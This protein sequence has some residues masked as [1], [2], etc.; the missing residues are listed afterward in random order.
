MQLDLLS[1]SDGVR[2]IDARMTHDLLL[3]VHY[4]RRLPSI[5]YAFG[6]FR[7]GNLVG[8]VTYGRPPAA[9]Q[10]SGVCGPEFAPLVYELNRLCLRDNRRN[11][12]SSLIGASLRLLP[13]PIVLISYADPEHGHTGTVYQATNWIY[14][15]RTEKRSEWKIRGQEHLHSQTIADR[16]RGFEKPSQ[17]IREHYGDKFYLKDRPRKHRYVCFVGSRTFKKQAQKALR[18]S[19]KPYREAA[20]NERTHDRSRNCEAI[21]SMRRRAP[22]TPRAGE[23]AFKRGAREEV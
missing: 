10:R 23:A 13:R 17:A 12:A 9:P 20:L 5:S 15:G 7:D 8:V 21:D 1:E 16:F 3:N 14:T 22:A 18:Y 4:A 11:E 6:M 19:I 2:A